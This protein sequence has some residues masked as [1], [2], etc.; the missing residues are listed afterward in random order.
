MV[1]FELSL[2]L[3]DER[4]IWSSGGFILT[5]E[6]CPVLLCLPQTPHELIWAQTRASAMWSRIPVT[7][8]RL[9]FSKPNCFVT[10]TGEHARY[11][12]FPTKYRPYKCHTGIRLFRWLYHTTN[13]QHDVVRFVRVRRWGTQLGKLSSLVNFTSN[14][15]RGWHSCIVFGQPYVQKP[16]Y[17][18]RY[19]SWFNSAC[20][21]RCWDSTSE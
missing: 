11:K 6:T 16:A 1:L 20:P 5:G 19:I 2:M 15:L 4:Y 13:L 8:V 9:I 12:R 17:H 14:E 7:R 18:D 21:G 10:A 3:P